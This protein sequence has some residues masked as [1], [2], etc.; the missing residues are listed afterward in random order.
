M[1]KQTISKNTECPACGHQLDDDDGVFF[2]DLS[3]TK[4]CQQ[5]K[6]GITYVKQFKKDVANPYC[7]YVWYETFFEYKE[8]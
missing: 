2:D 5:C 3:G 6:A 8:I 7:D 1:K 4:P